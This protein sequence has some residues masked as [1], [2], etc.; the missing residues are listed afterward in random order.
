MWL[1]IYVDGFINHH[2]VGWRNFLQT[3]L[4][5]NFFLMRKGSS[6][7]W[8]QGRGAGG[9]NGDIGVPS[10]IYSQACNIFLLYFTS[11]DIECFQNDNHE[12]NCTCAHVHVYMQMQFSTIFSI[13]WFTLSPMRLGRRLY[14][15]YTEDTSQGLFHSKPQFFFSNKNFIG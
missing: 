13:N 11:V 3:S 10:G 6:R 14:H 5:V 4:E 9:V 8:R 1:N 7:T 2:I 12:R 15:N